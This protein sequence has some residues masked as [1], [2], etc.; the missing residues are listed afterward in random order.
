MIRLS[1]SRFGSQLSQVKSRRNPSLAV[2][3]CDTF[4]E[5]KLLNAS[6]HFLSGS[7]TRDDQDQ[8][9]SVEL[10]FA[11]EVLDIFS[12]S[13]FYVDRPDVMDNADVDPKGK[14]DPNNCEYHDKDD[15]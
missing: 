11:Q 7:L 2:R 5:P 15:K 8:A 12:S 9:T 6:K 3:L 14:I 1:V 4:C 13:S 10:A